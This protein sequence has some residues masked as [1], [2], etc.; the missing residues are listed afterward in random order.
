MEPSAVVTPM[1]ASWRVVDAAPDAV[2]ALVVVVELE[3]SPAG[4]ATLNNEEEAMT[5]ETSVRASA[6]VPPV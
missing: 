4:A 5:W 2:S 3:P 6:V 1:I